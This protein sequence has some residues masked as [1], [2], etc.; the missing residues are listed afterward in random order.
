MA[1]VQLHMRMP[2]SKTLRLLSAPRLRDGTERQSLRRTDRRTRK[3][4]LS[5]RLLPN[6]LTPAVTDWLDWLWLLVQSPIQLLPPLALS[7]LS[8]SLVQSPPRALRRKLGKL[9]RP[10]FSYLQCSLKWVLRIRHRLKLKSLISPFFQLLSRHVHFCV[11]LQ[12]S[13]LF[14]GREIREKSSNGDP[15]PIWMLKKICTFILI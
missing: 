12:R 11:M 10:L 4:L 3:A 9:R 7:S 15:N 2:Y 6:R 8:G 5:P 13:Q 1:A 14:S